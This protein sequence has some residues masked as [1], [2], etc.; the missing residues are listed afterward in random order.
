MQPPAMIAEIDWNNPIILAAVAALIAAITG[1]INTLGGILNAYLTHIANQKIT[2][3]TKITTEAKQATENQIAKTDSAV[4]EV[5]NAVVNEA[6]A[7]RAANK[8]AA[9]AA[10][11]SKQVAAEQ[12]K[13]TEQLVKK[14][15]ELTESLNGRLAQKLEL[16]K[17]AG[18]AEAHRQI[19]EHTKR[20][21]G[22][23]ERINGVKEDVAKL[24]HKSD[25][26]LSILEKLPLAR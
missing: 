25:R 15:D 1:V 22:I 6:V 10:V 2:E 11:I 16:A 19:T 3:N 26:M 12:V 23:D 18:A 9:A 13:V 20:M 14:T 21:D 5:A 24:A 7:E 17:Q 4:K 8:V